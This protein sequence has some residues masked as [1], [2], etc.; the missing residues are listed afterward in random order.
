MKPIVHLAIQGVCV[1]GGLYKA[2]TR[3][4]ILAHLEFPT[5][6]WS[7]EKKTTVAG[8][9]EEREAEREASENMEGRQG[10]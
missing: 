10:Q 2:P 5:S 8:L 3:I 4:P 6:P 7:V 9:G 1:W